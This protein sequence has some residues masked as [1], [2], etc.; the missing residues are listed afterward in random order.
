MFTVEI[1]EIGGKRRKMNLNV[2]YKDS[3]DDT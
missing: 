1:S 3:F 2:N